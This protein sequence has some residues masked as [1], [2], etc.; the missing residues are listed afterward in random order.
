[1]AYAIAS[2][3]DFYEKQMLFSIKFLELSPVGLMVVKKKL[4]NI[5]KK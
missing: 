1:M 5:K 3:W 2:H 4:R